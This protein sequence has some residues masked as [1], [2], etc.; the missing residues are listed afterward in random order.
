MERFSGEEVKEILAEAANRSFITTKER[1]ALKEKN[2]TKYRLG[3]TA[4]V[5]QL[6]RK[7]A[8]ALVKSGAVSKYRFQKVLR[9]HVKEHVREKF[10]SEAAERIDQKGDLLNEKEI[11]REERKKK[12]RAMYAKRVAIDE[13]IKSYETEKAVEEKERL[14]Q[15][16]SKKKESSNFNTPDAARAIDTPI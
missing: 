16:K 13:R 15:T 4:S 10:G 6:K 1:G 11:E 14:E 2:L 7:I 9:Q 5:A 8:P 3:A 12:L